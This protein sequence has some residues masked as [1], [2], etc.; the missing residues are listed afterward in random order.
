MSENGLSIIYG[1]GRRG[2]KCPN[3]IFQE[4]EDAW[5]G[6]RLKDLK[7]KRKKNVEVDMDSSSDDEE[8]SPSILQIMKR[9]V[10]QGLINIL[11]EMTR[12]FG[13]GLGHG[14]GVRLLDSIYGRK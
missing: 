13:W 4:K 11:F 6:R 1:S 7:R 3:V 8:S 9:L 5:K 14:S 12:G 10:V 2:R